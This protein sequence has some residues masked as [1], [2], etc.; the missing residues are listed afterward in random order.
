ML[1]GRAARVLADGVREMVDADEW[2]WVEESVSGDFDHVLFGSSMP[3]LL[4][5]GMH[6]LQ[7]WNEAV[8]AGAWGS[9]FA[10]I[11]EAIRRAIDLEHWA[12]FGSSFQRFAHLLES[13]ASGERGAPPASVVILSGDVHH[14]YLA[15]VRFAPGTR[16]VSRVY[17]AVCSPFRNSLDAAQRRAQ[18]IGASRFGE[19]VGRALARSAGVAPPGF[20]WRALE[21]LEFDNQIGSLEL[22]GR[23]ATLRLE[24]AVGADGG[25]PRLEL[26]FERLLAR[27]DESRAESRAPTS[28]A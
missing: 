6:Y 2:A 4:A 23:R 5:P 19:V 1:D 3:Y 7:A 25:Q 15:R 28:A 10:R 16:A 21:P 12:A 26:V 24:R 9:T 13:L 8:C 17:Q 14:G 27:D 22:D 11:G 20:R 18:R